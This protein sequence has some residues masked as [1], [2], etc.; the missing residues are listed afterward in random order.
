MV[1]GGQ[2]YKLPVI[3][4]ADHEKCAI[5]VTTVVIVSCIFEIC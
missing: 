1:E 4:Q 3:N 5:M 2:M